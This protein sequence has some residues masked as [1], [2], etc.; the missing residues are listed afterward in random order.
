L[1]WE[2]SDN[3]APDWQTPSGQ[4]TFQLCLDD[5]FLCRA[6]PADIQLIRLAANL[7]IFH[8]TLAATASFINYGLVPLPTS[9][10]LKSGGLRHYVDSIAASIPAIGLEARRTS[11]SVE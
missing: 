5:K 1:L 4:L 8:V 3:R 7:A 2:R 9:C 10:A 6:I 11:T